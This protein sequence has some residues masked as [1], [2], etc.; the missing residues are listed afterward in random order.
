[1][2]IYK[3]RIPFIAA[4]IANA[5]INAKAI[6]VEDDDNAAFLK[7]LEQVLYTYLETDRRIHEEAQDL[8]ASKNGEFT[9]HARVK[10]ELAKKYNFG[11]GDDAI[12]WLTDQ[13]IDTLYNTEHV[14][15]IWEDNPT[16]RKLSRDALYKHTQ[17][18]DELD[19][20]VRAKIKNLAEG[21]VAWDVKYN[22]VLN[23]LRRQKGL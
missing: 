19:A 2:K 22:Q 3:G 16:I 9:A 5:L 15:E 13:I 7:D 8:I 21:S 4:E 18:D 20:E 1:M 23:D 6:E 10:R 11:L 17:I 14:A 12:D